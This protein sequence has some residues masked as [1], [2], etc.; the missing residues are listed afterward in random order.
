MPNKN[1]SLSQETLDLLTDLAKQYTETNESALVDK[2][3]NHYAHCSKEK[4]E[5]DLARKWIITKQDEACIKCK[6]TKDKKPKRLTS[7][8]LNE[9]R[10]KDQKLET[11]QDSPIPEGSWALYGKGSGFLCLD[12]AVENRG[13]KVEFAIFLKIRKLE[14]LK[15]A[16]ITEIDELAK[17][18]E[19]Y[20]G[21]DRVRKLT[22]LQEETN[23]LAQEY[24]TNKDGS[25][26]SQQIL[27]KLIQLNAKSEGLIS[28]VEDI[29]RIFI[30]RKKRK[31]QLEETRQIPQ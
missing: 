17:E 25:P 6:S 10:K 2:A 16:L 22:A 7:E 15:H 27:D 4:L 13:D 9:I 23:R 3:L 12:C 8:E 26:E 18:T 30:E 20:E 5:T 19:A 14:R 29:L 11:I 28:D 31:R 21:I 1:L 24:L